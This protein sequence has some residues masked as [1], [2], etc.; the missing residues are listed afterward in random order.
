M[1]F[2][3]NCGNSLAEESAFCNECG[4]RVALAAQ[5]VTKSRDATN[6]P[7]PSRHRFKYPLIVL[8]AVVAVVVWGFYIRMSTGDPIG[9]VTKEF[10]FYPEYSHGQ[11]GQEHQESCPSFDPSDS[12]CWH[13]TYTIP[14]QGCGDIT[15]SW[16]VFPER[17]AVL[18]HGT[19][20]RI[21]EYLYPLFARYD[22]DSRTLQ[23]FRDRS[24][25]LPETCQYK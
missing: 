11:W 19:S 5:G 7:V 23:D 18:Y 2:C 4:H 15:L 10:V 20:P 9:M 21:D 13:I 14:V 24:K 8:V 6:I 12:D 17:E 25:P 22:R 16:T 3:V 1:S